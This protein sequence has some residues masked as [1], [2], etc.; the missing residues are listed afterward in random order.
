MANYLEKLGLTSKI[1][2]TQINDVQ[3][4]IQVGRLKSSAT[5]MI[6]IADVGIGV[7]QVVPVLVALLVAGGDLV[8]VWL[9]ECE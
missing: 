1:Q 8:D 2:A 7:S 5:D 3:V 9:R 6:N 4:E